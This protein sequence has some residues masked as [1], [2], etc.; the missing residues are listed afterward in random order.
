MLNENEINIYDPV[1]QPG[2]VEF[3]RLIVEKFSYKK[4]S[5]RNLEHKTNSKV[6][7]YL[8]S[9]IN[10]FIFYR[11]ANS[12]DLFLYFENFPLF[13][14]V[15]FFG[16]KNINFIVHNNLEFAFHK[17]IHSFFYRIIAKRVNLIY[18]E[19]RLL[20]LGVNKFNHKKSLLI[21]HPI[22]NM[23]LDDCPKVKTKNVFVSSRNLDKNLLFKICSIYEKDSVVYTNNKFD[24][25]GVKNLRAGYID[26][27]DCL[28]YQSSKIY[29][30]GDYKYRC[31]GI[32][33]K[34]LSNPESEIVFSDEEY[35]EEMKRYIE[36][37]K[38]AI[39]ISLF[40]CL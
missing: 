38:I 20:K 14:C 37:N 26:D 36:E 34:A 12:G 30:T 2:H 23:K 5:T 32:L 39:K 4:K 24:L 29:L 21:N 22:I 28:L 27:F 17:N 19:K 13:L 6:Y 11:R 9:I 16:G 35:Y 8:K 18:L 1:S 15:V 10:H 33:Y 40:N 25:T 3:N 31:S 7:Y